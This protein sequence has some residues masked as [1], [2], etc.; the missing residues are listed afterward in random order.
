M[1][2]H[3]VMCFGDSMSWGIV[4][5]SRNR[6]AF[7]KRWPGILQG[8]LGPEVRVIEECLNGRTTAWND[9]FRPNRLGRDALLPLLQSHSPLDLVIVFLGTNDLQAMYNVGAYESSLG[10]NALVDVIQ[11]SRIEPMT[12]APQVLLVAPPLVVNPCGTMQE[13]FRGA[14]EK[15]L[16]FAQWYQRVAL[17][18]GCAFF[19][20]ATVITPSVTD[21]VH[22]DEPQHQLFAQAV[23]PVVGRLLGL[24][25]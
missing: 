3:H 11:D 17:D 4:P 10:A 9:P 20:A 8:L 24:G 22:L 2:K 6:H 13:K 19:D 14:A 18:R 12:Q 25:A 21:G 23:Q 16:G 1:F 5:G 15:S 7:E